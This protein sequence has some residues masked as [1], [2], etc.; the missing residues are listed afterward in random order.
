MQSLRWQL[1]RAITYI[2]KNRYWEKIELPIH[3]FITD[4]SFQLLYMLIVV[5][6]LVYVIRYIDSLVHDK[7]VDSPLQLAL[8][9]SALGGFIL[10]G[11]FYGQTPA[12]RI[13]LKRIAKSFLAAAISFIMVY[14]LLNIV[15]LMKSP[16]LSWIDQAIV[17]AAA[18]F[19]TSASVSFALALVWLTRIL[20]KL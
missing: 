20:R 8:V 6:I 3:Y 13:H 10:L 18:F 14:L 7:P 11:A 4:V 12:V 1:S 15:H 5:G 2:R 9:A 16:T 17:Y 19:I